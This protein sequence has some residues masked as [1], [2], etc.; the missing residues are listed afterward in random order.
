MKSKSPQIPKD[1]VFHLGEVKV[2]I[3]HGK[4]SRKS[5]NAWKLSNLILYNLRLEEAIKMK[6]REYFE[7]NNE[8]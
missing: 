1:Y 6:T 3:N 2:E 7:L 8:I 4:I 5:P